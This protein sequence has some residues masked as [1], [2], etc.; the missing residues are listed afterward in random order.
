MTSRELLIRR[1]REHAKPEAKH[2]PKIQAL[3]TEVAEALSAPIAS[4]PD[5]EAVELP[6]ALVKRIARKIGAV[7]VNMNF[8]IRGIIED[9]SP[10]ANVQEILEDAARFALR[11]RLASIPSPDGPREAVS[12]AIKLRLR[13]DTSEYNSGF[14]AG[15]RAAE[16]VV[17]Q[18]LPASPN[19]VTEV[20]RDFGGP[21]SLRG[22][23]GYVILDEFAFHDDP[24]GLFKAGGS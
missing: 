1:C 14:D 13:G 7:G 3:L 11:A 12:A 2:P 16:V 24:E 5:E 9:G 10:S 19:R 18:A 6:E 17:L 21:R 22:L 20:P 8:D 23:Q 4:I 15:L